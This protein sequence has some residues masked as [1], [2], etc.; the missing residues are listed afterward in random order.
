M[1]QSFKIRNGLGI[2]SDY[3]ILHSYLNDRDIKFIEEH[4]NLQK[5]SSSLFLTHNNKNLNF[6]IKDNL[7]F[8]FGTDLRYGK[9]YYEVELDTI[10]EI[11]IPEDDF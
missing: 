7:L 5:V 2:N 9:N 4:S 6:F 8:L 11:E 10:F 3:G 1:E